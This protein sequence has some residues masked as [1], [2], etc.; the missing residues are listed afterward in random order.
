MRAEYADRGNLHR[1]QEEGD[2]RSKYRICVDRLVLPHSSRS[3]SRVSAYSWM[4]VCVAVEITV[5]Q[6][7]ANVPQ[8]KIVFNT[9]TIWGV[10]GEHETGAGDKPLL[11][12]PT[13]VESDHSS[14]SKSW[15][16]GKTKALDHPRSASHGTTVRASL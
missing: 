15:V 10:P 4:R 11:T 13:S 5:L 12:L 16:R 7:H 6:T 1:Y 2:R 8:R 3:R 14:V 9:T